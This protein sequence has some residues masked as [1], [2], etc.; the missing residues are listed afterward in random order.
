M[1]TMQEIVAEHPVFIAAVSVCCH[2]IDQSLFCELQA[3]TSIRAAVALTIH[4]PVDCR[5]SNRQHKHRALPSQPF[6][7]QLAK[8]R[9]ASCKRL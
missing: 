2:S 4:W 7:K 6:R 5:H 1:L 9:A 3:V 8:P